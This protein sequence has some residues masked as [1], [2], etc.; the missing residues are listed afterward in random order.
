MIWFMTYFYYESYEH[1]IQCWNNDWTLKF[2]A[3]WSIRHLTNMK[4]R[5]PL[6]DNMLTRSQK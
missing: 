6:N 1:H 3:Y 5:I 2:F 4:I